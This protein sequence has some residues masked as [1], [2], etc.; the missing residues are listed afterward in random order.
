MARRLRRLDLPRGHHE[1][2][3][4]EL[5]AHNSATATGL[6]GRA[7]V[8]LGNFVQETFPPNKLLQNGVIFV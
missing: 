5:D 1:N 6:G 7:T 3:F 4:A 8:S 2:Q